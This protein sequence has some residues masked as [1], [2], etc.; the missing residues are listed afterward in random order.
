V[1]VIITDSFLDKCNKEGCYVCYEF[2]QIKSRLNREIMEH[3]KISSVI[4]ISISGTVDRTTAQLFNI[5]DNQIVIT[6]FVL[7]SVSLDKSYF[8]QFRELV[9]HIYGI[10]LF[11]KDPMLEYI[12]RG[13]P[14]R[15]VAALYPFCQRNLDC[16]LPIE[17]D[18]IK[19]AFLSKEKNIPYFNEWIAIKRP[20][21][22]PNFIES[23]D[24]DGNSYLIELRNKL[25]YA[26]VA[27]ITTL[28]NVKHH[29]ITG[30]GGIG[31]TQLAIAY[32][33]RFKH[34]YNIIFWI[35]AEKPEYIIQG[36]K[37]LLQ[38]LGVPS[39]K[40][41]SETI[42]ILKNTLSSSDGKWLLIFDNVQKQE[43]LRDP[44]PANQDEFIYPNGGH[45]IVLPGT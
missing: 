28:G 27:A 31:K 3:R 6:E 39:G 41:P 21:A 17:Y 34:Y 33:H 12:A 23:H 7:N 2:K 43:D 44:D 9:E 1:L 40:E 18:F 36:Y 15:A 13:L 29:A 20:L 26:K 10:P 22:N 30:L 19:Q 25:F 45:V 5:A 8:I 32:T 11:W 38:K 14:E 16:K 37:E 24:A 4:P 42:A 35:N